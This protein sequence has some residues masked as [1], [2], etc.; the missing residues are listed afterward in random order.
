VEVF[1]NQQF[2]TIINKRLTVCNID[3]NTILYISNDVDNDCLNVCNVICSSTGL[4]I[5]TPDILYYGNYNSN[6]SEID[7]SAYDSIILSENSQDYGAAMLESGIIRIFKVLPTFPHVDLNNSS[8]L[9]GLSKEYIITT[10]GDSIYRMSRDGTAP[11]LSVSLP[12]DASITEKLVVFGDVIQVGRALRVI[13][14]NLLITGLCSENVNW[15]SLTV[16]GF[17]IIMLSDNPMV[18]IKYNTG[19]HELHNIRISCGINTQKINI[20]SVTETISQIDIEGC[21]FIITDSGKITC[22]KKK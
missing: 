22:F 11:D 16:D 17:I 1:I 18:Y 3:T 21:S 20:D 10:I 14:N 9:L 2:L 13:S 15:A 7:I 19:T 4:L 5:N 6:L 8:R 12:V